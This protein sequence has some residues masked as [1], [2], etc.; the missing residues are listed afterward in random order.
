MA[1][2]PE[3]ISK[4][5]ENRKGRCG[6]LSPKASAAYMNAV[7]SLTAYYRQPQNKLIDSHIQNGGFILN[8]KKMVYMVLKLLII[9]KKV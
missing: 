3:E 8:G 9:I 2:L 7:K 5:W 1:V 4:A 6:Q